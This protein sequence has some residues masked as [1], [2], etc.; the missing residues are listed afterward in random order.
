M[1]DSTIKQI[2]D[3]MKGTIIKIPSEDFSGSENCFVTKRFTLGNLLER[4]VDKRLLLQGRP[5]A[6]RRL[7]PNQ[8]YAK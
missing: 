7:Q 5:V 1:P 2:L 4:L 3:T 8:P 6:W